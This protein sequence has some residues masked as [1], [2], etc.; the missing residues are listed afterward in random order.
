MP[1]LIDLFC[2]IAAL[3]PSPNLYL[4]K[5]GEELGIQR[6]KYSKGE[7]VMAQLYQQYLPQWGIL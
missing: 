7:E 2:Q 6:Q 1:F 4:L 3:L 5:P